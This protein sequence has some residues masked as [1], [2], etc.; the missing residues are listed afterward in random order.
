MEVEL[1][2][3]S[4]APQAGHAKTRLIPLL[5]GRA[6]ARLHREL[7]L[8]TLNLGQSFAPGRITLWCAPDSEHRFFRALRARYGLVLRQQRGIDLGA[9][10][11]HAFAAHGDALLLIGSDC[12]ALRKEHLASAAQALKGGLD[13]VF[14][15]A[16]DGG[17]VLVGLR[18]ACAGVFENIDWGSDRVMRQTR[19]RLTALGLRWQ[20]LETLWDVDR[21]EDLERFRALNVTQTCS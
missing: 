13:A 2:V 6:A 19:E 17:Y 16:E 5:G 1:A 4:K 9:R 10:M 8:L 21:P 7:T 11:H 15:P 18:Q 12:P 14:I 3:F 20:E